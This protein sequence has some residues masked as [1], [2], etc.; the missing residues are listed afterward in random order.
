VNIIRIDQI[1]VNFESEDKAS[2]NIIAG[3]CKESIALARDL[4]GLVSTD[5]C[6]IYIMKSP[7]KFIFQ[8]APWYW[9][10]A[11]ILMMPF[12]ISRVKQI[13]KYA[14]AWTQRYGKR[15]AIG[16]KPPDIIEQSDRSIGTRLFIEEPDKNNKT[17]QF[18][19]HELVH[20]CS[21]HL[22][23]PMWLNEG[24]AM[25]T[26]DHLVGKKTVRTDSIDLL[27]KF[28]PKG[29]PRSLREIYRG[30]N[31]Q[32]T[33]YTIRGYWLIRYLEEV[34]PGLLKNM[35]AQK[36]DSKWIDGHISSA[37]GMKSEDFWNKID[38]ILV[39]HFEDK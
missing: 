9:T 12:W 7:V 28:L 4:W 17:R 1:T 6:R 37:L 32:I 38:D 20:A 31:E 22:P 16:V 36:H 13:W 33:Y 15:I 26:V 30:G 29:P 27:K 8:S 21:S 19:C 10:V 11:L 24:I 35:F 2:A 23:L 18:T 14:G 39:S 34:R 3:T 25:E 5:E